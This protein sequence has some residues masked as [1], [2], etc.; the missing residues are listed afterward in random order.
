MGTGS[1]GKAKDAPPGATRYAGR[2]SLALTLSTELVALRKRLFGRGPTKARATISGDVITCVFEGGFT[3]SEATLVER[4]HEQ[5]VKEFRGGLYEA[6]RADAIAA[7]EALVG[8]RVRSY[9]AAPDPASGTEISVFVLE[10]PIVGYGRSIGQ[11]AKAAVARSGDLRDEQRALL[12]EQQQT[13]AELQRR[14]DR[15]R[16]TRKPAR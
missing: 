12:A 1:P 8:Q 3:R 2:E 10:A 6:S 16:Q 15:R 14:S 4:G 11:R 9:V 5:Q 7:V 13:A